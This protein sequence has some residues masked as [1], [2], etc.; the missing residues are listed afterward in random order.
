MNEQ[1][2]RNTFQNA[3]EEAAASDSLTNAVMTRVALRRS[4][5]P[6]PLLL[7]I[8]RN[9]LLALAVFLACA[10]IG[11]V[12]T[13]LAREVGAAMRPDFPPESLVVRMRAADLLAD[14]EG[15]VVFSGLQTVSFLE[16]LARAVLPLSFYLL[17]ACFLLS[18]VGISVPAIDRHEQR[19]AV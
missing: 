7:A 5:A 16:I 10:A 12:L 4:P 9:F 3:R 1:N 15:A 2:L 8:G 17:A 18:T 6:K 11:A 13:E 14:Q 19:S